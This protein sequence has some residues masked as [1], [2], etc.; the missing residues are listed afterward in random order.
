MHITR[1]PYNGT[2]WKDSPAMLLPMVYDLHS[3]ITQLAE[4]REH[5]QSPSV[6]AV[7]SLLRRFAEYSANQG[8]C[9]LFPA[10]REL[11]IN[12]QL[13]ND[14]PPSNQVSFLIIILLYYIYI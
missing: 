12:L 1:I 11:L 14:V 2:D 5:P 13:P 4:K 6:I 8:Q 10:V 9:S 7:G 3:N